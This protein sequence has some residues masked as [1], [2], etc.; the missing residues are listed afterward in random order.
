MLL[1]GQSQGAEEALSFPQGECGMCGFPMVP[2]SYPHHGTDKVGAA[3]PV[4]GQEISHHAS[5]VS[6]HNTAELT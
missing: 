1:H 2:S 4:P 3:N 6:P 5:E